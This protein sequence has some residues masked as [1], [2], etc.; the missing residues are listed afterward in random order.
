MSKYNNGYCQ[1]MNFIVGFLLKQTK[2]DEIKT[3]YILKSILPDIKGLF[4][5]DFPLLKKKY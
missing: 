3:Y 5:V 1:G 2:F 4:E